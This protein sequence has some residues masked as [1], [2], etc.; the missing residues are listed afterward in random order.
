MNLLATLVTLPYRYVY[1]RNTYDPI[2]AILATNTSSTYEA[3]LER[4]F[5]LRRGESQYVQIAVGS[6]FLSFYL[7]LT[8]GNIMS[9][10]L[11][12][13]TLRCDSSIAILALHLE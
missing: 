6:H 4:W 10:F 1:R 2:Q 5:R 9:K 8:R 11:G 7:T 13:G 3:E 12:C